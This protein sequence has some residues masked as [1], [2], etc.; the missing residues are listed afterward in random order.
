MHY[1]AVG[2]RCAVHLA[3]LKLPISDRV[4]SSI[5]FGLKFSCIDVDIVSL[6][7]SF[8]GVSRYQLGST[9]G[10]APL[11]VDCSSFTKYLFAQKGIWIP[12]L[13]IQQRAIGIPV[14]E[15]KEGDL[16]FTAVVKNNLYEKDS[17]DGVGHVGIATG[18]NTVVH[19][20]YGRQSVSED[21]FELFI[22]RGY[23]GVRRILEQD[24]ITFI[25]PPKYTIETSDDIKWLILQ[26]L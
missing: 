12:R 13:S 5:L 15:V 21:S 10:K 4:A 1:R 26:N 11:I 2:K 18:E 17:K 20:N 3:S 16:V 22:R 24:I 19:A 7:R 9:L 8:I 23:R 6:A 25:S 14:D